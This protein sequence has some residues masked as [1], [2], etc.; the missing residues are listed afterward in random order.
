[1]QGFTHAGEAVA[2]VG[3]GVEDGEWWL[4]HFQ[5]IIMIFFLAF[6][7]YVNLKSFEKRLKYC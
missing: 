2:R 1:M 4:L 7:S 6:V 5:N 3:E